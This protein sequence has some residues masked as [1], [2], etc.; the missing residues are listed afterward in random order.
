MERRQATAQDV[1][2]ANRQLY[3][4]VAGEYEAID[5]RRSPRLE[6]WLCGKLAA[7]RRRAPGGCLLDLGAG[8]G[9]V[10]R[11]A[12][13]HF[14]PRVGVDLSARILAASRATF[15]LGVAADVDA[16]PFPDDSF[17]A[18]TC[19]SVL[20]HLY[21]FEGLV[22]EVARVLRPGGVFYSDHDMDAAFRRRFRLPVALYRKLRNARS[23]Y[24]AASERVAPD[25]YDL[26]EWH[27]DG[28]DAS[29]LVGLLESAGF[30]VEA[31]FHWFGLSPLFDR[32]LGAKPRGRGWAPL[33]SLVATGGRP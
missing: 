10:T 14:A 32:L 15:D 9:L 22:A 24:H 33:L 26:S 17:D 27:G 13:G 19:F 2:D 25:V 16:L 12:E 4:A 28:V 7:L 5:D 11:C 6:A 18:V 30:S 8:S 23:K 20:H 21:A 1:K 3:D 31:T 29:R